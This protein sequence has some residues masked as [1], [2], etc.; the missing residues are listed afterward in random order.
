MIP[1]VKVAGHTG[2]VVIEPI[3]STDDAAAVWLR[4]RT[5]NADARCVWLTATQCRA[6]A[7]ELN[8]RA[9]YLASTTRHHVVRITARRDCAHE[10]RPWL[11]RLADLFRPATPR[12]E[13]PA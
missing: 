13:T 9:D 2:R 12:Q 5:A 4:P 1:G 11:T 7:A 8:E 6:L 3:T 10:P